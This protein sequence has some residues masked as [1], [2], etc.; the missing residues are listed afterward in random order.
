MSDHVTHVVEVSDPQKKVTQLFRFDLRNSYQPFSDGYVI[1]DA[2][3]ANPHYG[4]RYLLVLYTGKLAQ[5]FSQRCLYFGASVNELAKRSEVARV[6]I[7]KGRQ[8]LH[9]SS[10]SERIRRSIARSVTVSRS[11]GRRAPL[12]ARRG[13]CIRLPIG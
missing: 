6:R 11:S 9:R 1:A 2:Q 8:L 7:T 10:I 12:Y 5:H 13:L 3:I 4:A